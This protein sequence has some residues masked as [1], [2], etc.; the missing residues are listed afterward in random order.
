MKKLII[1]FLCLK[2]AFSFQHQIPSEY[3]NYN[4]VKLIIKD[5]YNTGDKKYNLEHIVPQSIFKGNKNLKSDMHNIILYPEKMNLHRSNYE[6]IS[7]FKLYPN[8]KLIDC[9]GEV[10]DYIEPIEDNNVCI[11]TS[12]KRYFLPQKKYRGLISRSCMY[13]LTTYPKYKDDI[14]NNVINPYTLLTWHHQYPVTDFEIYK[15]NKIYEYQ[16]NKN[17]FICDPKL[18]VEVM[19][20]ILDI[21]IAIFKNFIY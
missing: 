7:D 12:S 16:K 18:L 5:I 1:L 3:M 4:R 6:Y 2:N 8:S 13:V 11:K 20:D 14:L 15:N 19:Q 21:D 17:E 9:N 10:V